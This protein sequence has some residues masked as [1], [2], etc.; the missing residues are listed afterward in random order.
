[1]LRNIRP[2]GA[3]ATRSLNLPDGWPVH[4]VTAVDSGSDHH[5]MIDN[6]SPHWHHDSGNEEQHQFGL[7]TRRSR[8]IS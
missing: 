7:G 1:M 6:R 8:A 5:A 2:N 4:P 3:V